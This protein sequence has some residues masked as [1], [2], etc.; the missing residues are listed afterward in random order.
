MKKYPSQKILNELFTYEPKT[1]I[2]RW[3]N[4]KPWGRRQPGA[5]AGT[6]DKCDR[7]KISIN[8]KL[9]FA[10]RIIWIMVYGD[11]KAGLV[12]DHINGVPNDNSIKNLRLVTQQDNQKNT[13]I[14]K[15]NKVG[16]MGVYYCKTS[17]RWHTCIHVNY[18]KIH[19]GCFLTKELAI[20]IRKKAEMTYG[21][22]NNHGRK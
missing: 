10:H 17:K 4:I 7:V 9:F 3:K 16:V 6:T 22:H 2:L 18:K 8:N 13:R 11:I 20:E 1:G 19:L 5:I 12:I 14:T 15:N 21:F